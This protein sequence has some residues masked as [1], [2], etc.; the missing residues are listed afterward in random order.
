MKA[1]R[2]SAFLLV[3][4]MTAALAA[5]AQEPGKPKPQADD[6]SKPAAA[7]DQQQPPPASQ[8]Q[9][10]SSQPATA[11]PPEP[12][13]AGQPPANDKDK[14]KGEDDH[15]KPNAS[16][17]S[18]D[19]LFFTMPNY[20]SIRAD[21]TVVPLTPGQKYKLVAR[22][23]FDPVQLGYWAVIAG[24]SQAEN[25]EPGYGQGAEGYGK[26]Y[27]ATIADSTIEN[28]MVGAVFPSVLKTDPRYFQNGKGS[29]LHRTKYA[30]SRIFVTRTDS[31]HP[32]FNASE[33]FGSAFAAGI[34]TYSYHPGNDRTVPNTLSVWGTQVGLDSITFMLKEFWPD[35]RRAIK[36]HH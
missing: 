9:K 27:G 5:G 23:T 36:K 14:L 6:T 24:I 11:Q 25:S 12:G 1:L 30:I 22:G 13:Q 31:G 21:G 33:I 32:T 8:P 34:S 7:P 26:R 19:R 3:G 29:F 16:G 15:L 28:F 20:S 18:N 10:D 17:G 4:L 2:L 35:L